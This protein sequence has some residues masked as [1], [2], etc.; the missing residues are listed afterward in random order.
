MG[1]SAR[2]AVP[3]LKKLANSNA[4]KP[5]VEAAIRA[6]QSLRGAR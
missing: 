6:A 2:V 4:P 3:T 5:L 1:A